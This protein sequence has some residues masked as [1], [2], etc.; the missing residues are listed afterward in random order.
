MVMLWIFSKQAWRREGAHITKPAWT[1]Y[2]TGI[3]VCCHM[4]TVFSQTEPASDFVWKALE[5]CTKV[6]WELN[7]ARLIRLEEQFRQTT[8]VEWS[9]NWKG[10]SILPVLRQCVTEEQR[11]AFLGFGS[12]HPNGYYRQRC[13]EALADYPN[14]A[15]PFLF[16]RL[17]DWVSPVGGAAQIACK[18]VLETCHTEAMLSALPYLQKA[19]AGSRSKQF[20]SEQISRPLPT[21]CGNLIISHIWIRRLSVRKQC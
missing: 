2:P 11:I 5:A 16:L 8:S 9:I 13:A 14:V 4:C 19:K 20:V 10:I 15:L 17:N 3:S 7:A 6:Y 1:L 12:F 18:T 21:A